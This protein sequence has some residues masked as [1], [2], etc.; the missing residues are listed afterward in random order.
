METWKSP[1]KIEEELA[2]HQR[3]RFDWY[4]EEV[5]AG[6]LDEETAIAALR[7]EMDHVAELDNA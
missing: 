7:E 1:R 6:R 3:S 4:M 5:D 2:A